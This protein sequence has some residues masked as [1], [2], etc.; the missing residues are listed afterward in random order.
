MLVCTI[1]PRLSYWPSQWSLKPVTDTWILNYLHPSY[2]FRASLDQKCQYTKIYCNFW[3]QI[4]W[5]GLSGWE[6][7]GPKEIGL[8]I[9]PSFRKL[10][11]LNLCNDFD[12]S[13]V[14]I[15]NAHWK[16][17]AVWTLVW[18]QTHFMQLTVWFLFKHYNF[19]YIWDSRPREDW[20]LKYSK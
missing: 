19:W 8:E 14:K 13:Y 4:C 7:K 1:K 2:Y 12:L 9:S 15:Q 5:N 20:V 10:P 16:W 11:S 18:R 17:W 3:K 6:W